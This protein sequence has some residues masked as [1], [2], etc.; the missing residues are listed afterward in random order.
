M[1]AIDMRRYRGARAAVLLG[2]LAAVL[3]GCAR[4]LTITQDAYINTAMHIGRPAGSKSGEPL[5]INAELDLSFAT[6][7][8]REVYQTLATVPYGE[9]WSYGELAAA[10]GRPGASRA[11]GSANAN[12]P[13]PLI[14][15]CHR[16]IRA[17]GAL[18]GFSAPGGV[19]LKERMLELEKQG[20]IKA[21][22]HGPK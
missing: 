15:P 19:G 20:C 2:M 9:T 10:I 13:V 6:P 1:T 14:V 18:G 4:E 8:Q 5:E 11:V 7:F 12:N 16:V 21:A 22:G 17:D 3:G